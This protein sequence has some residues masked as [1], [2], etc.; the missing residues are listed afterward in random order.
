MSAA[1]A[2]AIDSDTVRIIRL[3]EQ[4]RGLKA[5]LATHL[6]K[7]DERW[8]KVWARLD[9]LADRLSN[10]DGRIAGYLVAATLLGTAV[11]FIAAYVLKA[12]P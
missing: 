7:D 11:A 8:S 12:S 9:V 3:E 6:E 1:R 10:L 2:E 4:V 5:D